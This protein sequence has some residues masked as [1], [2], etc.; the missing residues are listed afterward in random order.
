MESDLHIC[1]ACKKHSK[2]LLCCMELVYL[3]S[4][5]DCRFVSQLLHPLDLLNNGVLYKFTI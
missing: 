3:L 5:C 1:G 4:C 2:L